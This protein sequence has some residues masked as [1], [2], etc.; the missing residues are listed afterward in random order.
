MEESGRILILVFLVLLSGFFSAAEM[1]LFSLSSATV[2]AMIKQHKKNAQ[3]VGELRSHPERLLITILVGNNIVNIG[4]S[5]LATV[6]AIEKLGS[7]GAGVA[8][9]VMTFLILY[10]GEIIPKTFSQRFNSR[11][12][13][14]LAPAMHTIQW[15]L[16]PIV[17]C[18]QV[19]THGAQ[20][21]L[22]VKNSKSVVSEEEVKAMVSMSHETGQVEEGE[23]AMIEKVFLLND[24]RVQDVMTPRSQM[25]SLDASATLNDAFRV[26]EESEYSRLPIFSSHG[27]TIEGILHVKEVFRYITNHDVLV[28][29]EHH[30]D[31]LATPV[32][33]VMGPAIVVN[34]IDL[35]DDVMRQFQK[36][37]TH[38]AVV[39]DDRGAVV[40]V[41]TLEDI[42]E[43]LVGEIFDESD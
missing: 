1:S 29:G 3:L 17:Y 37:G 38:M 2:R 33:A 19:L 31:L 25:V 35:L 20:R 9:G 34:A 30:K 42:L 27:R 23:K 21:V 24:T 22:R 15:T 14:R 13:R 40:G 11:V 41:V 39:Q 18:F 7:I 4:A 5:S 36:P 43:E 8:T 12:A 16:T 26:M 10:F 32:T 6:V 28:S